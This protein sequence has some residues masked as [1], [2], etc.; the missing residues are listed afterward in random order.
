MIVG[1][2][3]VLCRYL[4][5]LGSNICRFWVLSFYWSFWVLFTR[6]FRITWSGL[7]SQNWSLFR[8]R[9]EFGPQ[10]VR[11]GL[12]P[13]KKCF[14]KKNLFGLFLPNR[15]LPPTPY[16][17]QHYKLKPSLNHEFLKTFSSFL[18]KHP[19]PVPDST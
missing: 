14:R 8:A 12:E 13:G 15:S 3:S 16:Y 4:W 7:G 10:F 6:I 9:A 17:S 5:F 2:I 1:R 11:A 18:S 19:T